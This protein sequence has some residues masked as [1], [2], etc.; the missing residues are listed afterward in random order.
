MDL[1]KIL[2]THYNSFFE[3]YL[4][5]DKLLLVFISS[6]LFAYIGFDQVNTD[7][8]I[9]HCAEALNM[10]D[11]R[12]LSNDL[13]VMASSDVLSPRIGINYIYYLFLKLG[14]SFAAANY[15]LY[16]LTCLIL[17]V[18]VMLYVVERG[19]AHTLFNVIILTVMIGCSRIGIYAGF[20]LFDS[21]A[22]PLC[23]ATSISFI[24]ICLALLGKSSN[25]SYALIATSSIIHIHEGIYGLLA[26]SV[27]TLFYRRLNPFRLR[28]FYLA[29]CMLL[30]LTIPN[31]LSSMSIMS[32]S[33]FYQ[34]YVRWRT[35]HH[36]Y[37]FDSGYLPHVFMLLSYVS[38]FLYSWRQA[39]I[40][41]Y[42]ILY[43][44]FIV[45]FVLIVV[46]WYFSYEVLVSKFFIKLYLPK[47]VKYISFIFTLLIIENLADAL[48]KGRKY[49]VLFFLSNLF[50][51]FFSYNSIGSGWGNNYNNWLNCLFVLTIMSFVPDCY[52]YKNVIWTALIMVCSY[53]LMFRTALDSR[54]IIYIFFIFVL[55]FIL[56]TRIEK[57]VLF[58]MCILLFKTN[59]NLSVLVNSGHEV[60]FDKIIQLK[61][62]N[63]LFDVSKKIKKTTT[64][65]DIILCDAFCGN[66]EWVQYLSKRAIYADFGMLPA[67][68][69]G[70]S[71]WF[72]RCKSVEGFSKWSASQLYHFMSKRNIRYVLIDKN[73]YDDKSFLQL[74]VLEHLTDHYCFLRAK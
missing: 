54:V 73:Q 70:I 26:L 33:E 38:I 74:F 6:V 20:G 72:Q 41:D 7:T 25:I 35:P 59:T 27:I 3:N 23:L 57:F 52:K 29:V 32:P 37:I 69:K 21:Q 58:L 19:M 5:V 43:G 67:S 56:N 24:A 17:G 12:L 48:N 14:F 63:E 44:L 15:L 55:S 18:C 13:D 60:Y 30:V 22:P 10:L 47:A 40:K 4:N 46:L 2:R 65:D 39:I 8:S 49:E 53:L 9:S 11:S 31:L 50:I 16:M 1:S 28:G 71:E 62:G 45:S 61:A 51:I 36:L 34:V 66:S 68:E 64:F 42:A